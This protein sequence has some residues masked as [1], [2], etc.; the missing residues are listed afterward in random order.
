VFTSFGGFIEL[1]IV[2]VLKLF[3]HQWCNGAMVQ[4]CNGAIIH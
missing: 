4:W 2:Q 3:D 1:H